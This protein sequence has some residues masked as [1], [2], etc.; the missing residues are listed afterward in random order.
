[1]NDV[2]GQRQPIGLVIANGKKHLTKAEIAERLNSEPT[3][4]TDDL[5][6][7]AYL[8]AT[9]KKR[10]NKIADQLKK[11]EVMGETD[12]ETLAR[13]ITAQTQYEKTTKDLRDLMK[14]RPDQKSENYLDDLSIWTAI[15]ERLAKLQ[16][17]YFKQAQTA[18]TSLGLTISA[19]CKLVV[20]KAAEEPKQNKFS[21][22]NQGAG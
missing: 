18:A 2:S 20:P 12:T 19:R 14:K 16:D 6:A 10:F 1:V 21:R 11:L 5:T 17:R 22:F 9:E 4:C 8:S 15:E 13:Y 7:P 3:P